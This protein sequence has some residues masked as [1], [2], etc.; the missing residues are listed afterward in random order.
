MNAKS[1]WLTLIL[2]TAVQ[3]ALLLIAV[4]LMF[5][6]F[7]NRT[8][9]TLAAD[10][11]TN[12]RLISR[13]I[14]AEVNDLSIADVGSANEEQIEQLQSVL[15]AVQ[16]PNYG[17]VC[18][19]DPETGTSICGSPKFAELTQ[20]G[21][22]A[23]VKF[24]DSHGDDAS[25]LSVADSSKHNLSRSGEIIINERRHYAT[26]CFHS[27][28]NGILVVAQRP[29]MAAMK[30]GDKI[31]TAQQVFFAA[32]LLLGFVGL[33][34]S[35][36]TVNRITANVETEHANFEKEI[37]ASGLQISRTQNAVIFG[38]AKLAESRDNDTGEHL[39][40][41]RSYVLLLAKDLRERLPE[42]QTHDFVH[43]LALA[44]S[45]HDVG[46]VGIPDSILLKPG[47]L[48]KA[49]RDVMELHTLIGGECLEA[50]QVRL[51]E[52][53]PFMQLAIQVAF[54]HHERWDGQ[55]YPHGLAGDRI[56][57]AARIVAVADVYDALTSKRPYKK[58]LSHAES[59]GIILAGSGSQFDP[60]VVAAFLRHEDEFEAIS[61]GQSTLSD[62][63]VR[64]E[65]H[66]LCERAQAIVVEDAQL[67]S[68][69]AV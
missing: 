12:I 30:V 42:L 36:M 53:N 33:A 57:L 25:L 31:K 16:M 20:A 54:Y 55:G 49:E 56:P 8:Q 32:T 37:V 64:S 68:A 1:G 46:K 41:I 11:Y 50:I 66:M 47:R 35:L 63:D 69:D 23:K 67:V 29:S 44:S 38:L 18:I 9:E 58:P 19:V 4:V 61:R 6:W 51:G 59:K 21:T 39:D 2:I 52:D 5:S 45:L 40:R 13:Q 65:F 34:A 48:T 43:N 15:V 60:E 26:A 27:E 14:L 24:D 7:G 22:F 3:L 10:A 17:F 28:F 62:D